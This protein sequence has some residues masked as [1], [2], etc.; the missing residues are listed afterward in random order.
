MK[1]TRSQTPSRQGCEMICRLFWAK[2][3]CQPAVHFPRNT[4]MAWIRTIPLEEADEKLRKAIEAQR[5]LYPKEYDSPVSPGGD[6]VVAS[7]TLMPGALYHIF[8]AFG[9][10]MSPD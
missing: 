9:E 10:M 5:A 1:Y 3:R 7:H 2:F 6:S 8:S 4:N